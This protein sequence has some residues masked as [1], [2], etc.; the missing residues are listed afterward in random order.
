MAQSGAIE[1]ARADARAPLAAT[2]KA[3]PAPSGAS[4]TMTLAVENMHCG[5]CMRKVESRAARCSGRR[6]GALQP[7]S[8][9]RHGGVRQAAGKRR[10]AG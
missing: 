7:I 10:A 1:L 8:A 2:G 9:P 5:G 3:K 4:Q 6:F